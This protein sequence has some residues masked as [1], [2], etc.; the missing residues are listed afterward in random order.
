MYNYTPSTRHVALL[1]ASVGFGGHAETICNI[2]QNIDE[3]V[4]AI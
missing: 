3:H 1:G 4:L 2:T